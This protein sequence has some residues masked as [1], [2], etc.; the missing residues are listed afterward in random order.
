[1]L[2]SINLVKLKMVWL[3]TTLEIELELG[4]WI[5]IRVNKWSSYYPSINARVKIDDKYP[6]S[7]YVHCWHLY[8]SVLIVQ[9]CSDDVVF[10]PMSISRFISNMGN[11]G[12]EQTILGRCNVLCLQDL[13]ESV[14]DCQ[15]H[16][17]Q[18]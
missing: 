6:S 18:G 2:F 15:G 16:T 17:Q 1:M 12:E 7:I 10:F 9:I 14:F 3:R 13:L 4:T 8:A 11:K 5:K